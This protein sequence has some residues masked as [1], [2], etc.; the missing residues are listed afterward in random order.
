MKNKKRLL[1]FVLALTL[2]VTMFTPVSAAADTTAKPIKSTIYVNGEK[3]E[4]KGYSIDNNS[5]FEL[6][7]LG[8]SVN[9]GVKFDTKGNNIYI[10]TPQT[11]QVR[12]LKKNNWAPDTYSALNNLIKHNGILSSKYDPNNKPYV[13]FDFDNTTVINDVEE[14]LLIYQ[15]E[16]L[17]FKIAPKQMKEVLETGIP[18]INKS[19]GADYNNLT[20]E[21]I[22]TD[23][24]N[25]YEYLY[26]NY[27]GFGAGGKMKLAE[28]QKTNEYKDFITKVRYL[29][30]GVNDTFD[31]SVGYPWVTY[32][33]TGMTPAEVYKL[34]DESHTYWRNYGKFTKLTWESPK[35]LPGKAGV[36]SVS[37]KTGITF[38][39]E[40]QDLYKTLM[41]NGIDVYVC[42]ASFIDVIKAACHEPE[43]ELNVKKGNVYA[44]MLKLDANGRYINKYDNNY[45]QTQGK[46]KSHTID[47]FIRSK[48]NN[49]GPIMVAG[50]SAGDYNMMIDYAD[51]QLGLLFNRYRKDD[52]KKLAQ[53][54]EK[55]LGQS[56]AKYVLQGRDENKGVLRPTEKTI[57]LGDAREVLVR[58]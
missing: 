22:A 48:Y 40:V 35:A 37:Y 24:A 25:D 17:R 58:K 11:K 44:M 23:C 1:A 50:D 20:V 53:M 39:V 7:D 27:E 34:A 4:I 12:V 52:T 8:E 33:F 28:I 46:G 9:F 15:L 29:Y 3:A 19:F 6:R 45:F 42:S 32:L 47:K 16:N 56:S 51:M 30:D 14:A 57:L 2:L 21:I 13:V 26:K 18:D 36:V 38:P 5:Y 10:S 43:Y 31:A 55:V 41:D 49:R 54:A